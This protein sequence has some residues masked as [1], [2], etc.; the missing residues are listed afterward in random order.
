MI[1]GISTGK[2]DLPQ[3]LAAAHA[4]ALGFL[5]DIASTERTPM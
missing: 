2:L 1:S 4:H 3:H 5:A